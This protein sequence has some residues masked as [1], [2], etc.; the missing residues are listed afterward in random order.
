LGLDTE[1]LS[2]LMKNTDTL[3]SAGDLG[4]P[5][6]SREWA[7]AVKVEI[8]LALDDA[9][10]RAE[11]LETWVKGMEE[12]RGYLLL[13]DPEGNP[14]TSYK[15]FCRA[16]PPWGIGKDPKLIAQMIGKR[17]DAES[18]A[19]EAEE[20]NLTLREPYRPQKDSNKGNNVTLIKARGNNADYRTARIK[21]DYPE[22]F[23]RMKAGEF[24]SVNQAAIAAGFVPPPSPLKDLQRAWN[25]ASKAERK[26]FMA[27][28]KN[29]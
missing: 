29:A 18:Q 3:M 23:K 13:P 7:I 22:I 12:S 8:Q 4:A 14:F 25:R 1:E 2:D 27:W 17:K 6:G 5:P 19:L 16:K 11:D 26:E 15:A 10:R 28:M 24:T 9:T 20:T 21:R